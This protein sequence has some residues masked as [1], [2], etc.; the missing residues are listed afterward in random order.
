MLASRRRAE[1]PSLLSSNWSFAQTGWSGQ[2]KVAAGAARLR[3]RWFA[4]R[5]HNECRGDRHRL[6][7]LNRF[8]SR[9]HRRS[10]SDRS[11]QRSRPS[12]PMSMKNAYSASIEKM[13][14]DWDEP[15]LP[16]P[17][18]PLMGSGHLRP[19]TSQA[20]LRT[21]ANTV[22]RVLAA[23]ALAACSPMPE[24]APVIKGGR[25]TSP[26]TTRRIETTAH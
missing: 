7:T 15:P 16:L 17:S 1:V 23:M 3:V 19:A 21:P 5:K 12:L 2:R 4:R 22:R 11:H 26:R 8:R 14:S 6:R 13:W 20:R 10:R 18:G 9:G 25:P 24:D